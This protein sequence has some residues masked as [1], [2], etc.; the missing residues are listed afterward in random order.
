MI[1]VIRSVC[2]TMGTA[3]VLC[4]IAFTLLTATSRPLI[5]KNFACLCLRILE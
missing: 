2:S 5:I 4:A 3:I 1:I